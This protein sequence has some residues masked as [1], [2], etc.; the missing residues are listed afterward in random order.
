MSKITSKLQVTI[1]KAIA[2]RFGL[3]P[4]DDVEFVPAGEVIRLE[5]RSE[6]PVDRS[7]HLRVELFDQATQRHA[8]RVRLH[9]VQ[10]SSDRGWTRDELYDRAHSR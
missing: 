10:P 6:Q 9:P 1:P 5:R 7:R 2:E 8:D 3:K 4:G